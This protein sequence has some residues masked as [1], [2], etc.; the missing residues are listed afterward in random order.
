[1]T[2]KRRAAAAA[3]PD[4]KFRRTKRQ[5]F[6]NNDFMNS[7]ESNRASSHLDSEPPEKADQSPESQAESEADF[8]GD[9]IQTAQDKIMSELTRLKDSEGQEVAYPFIGKPDRNLYRDYYEII[10]HPVSLRSIQKRVRGTDSRKNSSKTTAYPTWQSFEE[11]VS[12]VWRNA[13]EY[14]E[15]DSDI[16]ILAGVLEDH[17]HR[18][19][20]EAKKLVPN[21]LEVDGTLD[22]P[23]I[24][25]KVGTAVPSV[26][27]RLTLRMPGQ[28]SDTLPKHNGHPSNVTSKNGSQGHAQDIPGAGLARQEISRSPRGCSLGGQ[29]ASPRSSTTATPSGSEQHQNSS[30]GAQGLLGS[31]TN[32]TTLAMSASQNPPNTSSGVSSGV[33]LHSSSS[34]GMLRLGGKMARA[35]Y[36]PH[37]GSLPIDSLLRRSGQDP[38]IALIRNVRILTHA[39]LSLQPDFCLDIPPSSLVSQQNIIV[40][41]PPSH[42]VLTVRPRLAASTSQRQVKI[43]TLM[44]MERLHSS[45]DAT[46]LSY[47]IHLHPGM[48]RV[49]VEAIAAPARGV[50]KSGPPGSDIDY[51]RVTLFFNLLC[52]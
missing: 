21:P 28:S 12:Y 46:T 41:L 51:E 8:E 16:S 22:M 27:Q 5:K 23:R 38:G 47:D 4:M 48:T 40:H 29:L 7:K 49:D 14:N 45:G 37:F 2:S 35:P 11:E 31:M 6:S 20:A 43:V 17:F 42:N 36:Q 25:L 10:Q 13:R 52:Q 15:D 9:S 33:P 18:R 34:S 26:A 32:A 3:S 24:K 30:I 44:G 50:P 1:M 39:S 19:V